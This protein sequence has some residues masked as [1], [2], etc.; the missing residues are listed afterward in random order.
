[1]NEF[2]KCGVFCIRTMEYS[3]AI[4]RNELLIH[5][6]TVVNLK[7]IMVSEEA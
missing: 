2:L 6:A 3:L 7:Y 1:M 4:K 5:A